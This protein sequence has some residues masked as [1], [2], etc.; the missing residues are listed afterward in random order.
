MN[1]AQRTTES[2]SSPLHGHTYEQ[3]LGCVHCGLCLPACPTYR[4]TGVEADSPRGRI[5]LVR[6]LAE[7]RIEDPEV[8]RHH[9][10]RWD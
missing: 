10:D 8:V 6:A 9:L 1:D 2:P 4:S 3:T 7:G 5:Y